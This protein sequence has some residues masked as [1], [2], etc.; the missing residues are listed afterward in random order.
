MKRLICIVMTVC[1][2]ATFSPLY[3]GAAEISSNSDQVIYS[4]DGSYTI[5]SLEYI[6]VRATST[7]IGYKTAVHYNSDDEE[8]WRACLAATFRYDKVNPAVC[9]SCDCEITIT[10]TAWHI[11]TNETSISGNTA[12]AEVEMLRKILGITFSRKSVVL[13]LTCD[14]N[15]NFI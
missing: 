1:L 15:G 9:T 12:T 13:T 10:D 14:P 11:G 2:L 5:I 6:D 4:S 3:A 8:L 7:R